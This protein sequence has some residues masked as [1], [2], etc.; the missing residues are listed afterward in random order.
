MTDDNHVYDGD[1]T[2][3]LARVAEHL[4]RWRNEF[5]RAGFTDAEAL[6]LVRDQWERH[7]YHSVRSYTAA[8]RA[9][10]RRPSDEET[11]AP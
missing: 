10:M 7:G 11:S 1:P 9:A 5:V 4:A 3:S 2:R 6:R 8:G